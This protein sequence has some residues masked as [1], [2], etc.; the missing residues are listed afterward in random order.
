MNILI[1]EGFN[2]YFSRIY[3]K[4][5]SLNDYKTA[6]SHYFDFP[7]IN[8][9]PN[10]GVETEIIIGNTNQKDTSNTLIDWDD[11]T[12]PDYLVCY[13]RTGVPVQ[14]NI[15]SRWFILDIN[16]TRRGQYK[17]SLRRDLTADML[18]TSIA[19]S[20]PVQVE[21]AIISDNFKNPLLL[22]HEDVTVNQ[23][24]SSREILL[25]DNTSVPW[26]VL[27]LAKGTL[28]DPNL[29]Q[30]TVPLENPDL[31]ISSPIDEWDMYKFRQLTPGEDPE[32][33]QDFVT[34][35]SADLYWNY[36][37]TNVSWDNGGAYRATLDFETYSVSSSEIEADPT[38]YQTS[39]EINMQSTTL[40]QVKNHMDETIANGYGGVLVSRIGGLI[41]L[42]KLDEILGY[43]G[44]IIQ[45]SQNKLWKITVVRVDNPV[46]Q[47]MY[48]SFGPLTFSTMNEIWNAAT[49][50]GV[51]VP[52][53]GSMSVSVPCVNYRLQISQV[54]SANMSFILNRMSDFV[55]DSPLF[56]VIAL[57][58]GE[59]TYTTGNSGAYS[60]GYT[61]TA[62]KSMQIAN[63]IAT[64]LTS[65]RVLDLQ[66][67][68]YC[69]VYIPRGAAGSFVE[70]P[71]YMIAGSK[72]NEMYIN[73]L[74]DVGMVLEGNTNQDLIFGVRNITHS[75]DINQVVSAGSYKYATGI[76]DICKRVKYVNDCTMMRLCS[77]NY[78]GLFEFNLAKNGMS[79][80]SFNVDMTLRPFNPYIH[81]NPNFKHIYG[82]DTDD[83]R[84]LICGGDFSLGILNDQFKQYELQNKNY[85]AIFD[86][87]IQNLD[88]NQDI[89]RQQA[90]WSSIA[91]VGQ[92]AVSGGALGFFSGGL[93]GAAI[94]AA[95]GGATSLAGGIA[96]Y[97]LL[98]RSQEEQRSFLKDNY[99]LQLGNVRALP[100][101]ITRTSALT[102]NN[103]IFPFIELYECTET[104]RDAYLNKID[105]DGMTVGVIDT[106]NHYVDI[107]NP[108]LK[109][110]QGRIIRFNG[111]FNNH[112]INELNNEL[113]KGVYI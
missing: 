3:K 69:P 38:S 64:Q 41:G 81:V 40:G 97:N 75:F 17:L 77:P 89:Q 30:V 61:T 84:G 105:Y 15:I 60:N 106:L 94:G 80:E 62:A 24:K 32:D 33:A 11:N 37:K 26:L 78:A 34:A 70:V 22:N 104:E 66:L 42:H 99:K 107:T 90:V 29:P 13:E 54:S 95:V 16:R 88:V 44:K 9:N 20:A 2:N 51:N 21:K 27:Y 59:I 28:T 10:D 103:K 112:E 45:D 68:P 4:C 87:Q 74:A 63:C 31:T 111:A 79:V 98:K 72:S 67:L 82:T 25:K 7:S 48:T 1:L 18:S 93:P 5:N 50:Q 73:T 76:D 113:M 36:R 109:Y 14:D 56:D 86:R 65:S 102:A 52:V 71:A 92:G 49:G 55:S 100:T 53:R 47:R 110:I 91:G 35:T 39:Y 19:N 46:E 57:P 108:G 6:S 58:Y 43:D 96:D 23:I 101:T 85:Q 8:F 12:S 83:Q